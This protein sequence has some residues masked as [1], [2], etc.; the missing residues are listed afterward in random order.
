MYSYERGWAGWRERWRELCSHYK[1]ITK[2]KGQVAV[3]TAIKYWR[4]RERLEGRESW[5]GGHISYEILTGKE[6]KRGRQRGRERCR[7]DQL[8]N[9]AIKY[10]QRVTVKNRRERK[11]IG[12]KGMALMQWHY[13]LCGFQVKHSFLAFNANKAPYQMRIMKFQHTVREDEFF[14]NLSGDFTLTSGICKATNT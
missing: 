7:W 8:S 5:G 11:K 13:I 12:G 2:K 1:V 4:E 9:I 10:C 3:T 6:W 14:S